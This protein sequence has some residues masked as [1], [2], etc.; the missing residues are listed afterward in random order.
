MTKWSVMTYPHT[1]PGRH[2]RRYSATRERFTAR[3]A[4]S[5]RPRHRRLTL[6]KTWQRKFF[7]KAWA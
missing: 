3:R 2:A 5:H 4:R 7:A 6:S 1:L